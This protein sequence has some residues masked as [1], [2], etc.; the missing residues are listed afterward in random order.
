[1]IDAQPPL[2]DPASVYFV[3]LVSWGA[4]LLGHMFFDENHAAMYGPVLSQRDID[5]RI[6]G[7]TDHAWLSKFMLTRV[8]S[9][10]LGLQYKAGISADVR[11]LVLVAAVQQ[12]LQAGPVVEAD[13]QVFATNEE[14]KAYEAALRD[15]FYVVFNAR[16]TFATLHQQQ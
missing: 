15:A 3:T 10:W 7:P 14:R 9:C 13:K 12:L 8:D 1:M 2:Q 4:M 6:P 11:L 16:Y 5:D